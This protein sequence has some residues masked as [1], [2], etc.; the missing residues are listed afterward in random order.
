ML[1]APEE[2]R[3][4]ASEPFPKLHHGRSVIHIAFE[5]LRLVSGHLEDI[6]SKTCF[7]RKRRATASEVPWLDPMP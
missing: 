3:K 6:I 2:E 5:T 7:A 1:L 4:R